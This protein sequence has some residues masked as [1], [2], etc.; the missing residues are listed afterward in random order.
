MG[1]SVC[2][3]LA[4]SWAARAIAASKGKESIGSP[5]ASN[6]A[7][8]CLDSQVN[9]FLTAARPLLATW[10]ARSCSVDLHLAGS[11]VN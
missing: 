9:M 8:N 7:L 3:G 5:S 4:S 6:S 11:M 2:K 10:P 1:V